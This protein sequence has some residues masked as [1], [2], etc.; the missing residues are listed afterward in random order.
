MLA[1]FV[2]SGA[3]TEFR[4]DIADPNHRPPPVERGPADLTV[5]AM[6]EIKMNLDKFKPFGNLLNRQG[7]SLQELST[8]RGSI[9]LKPAQ[10]DEMVK[11]DIDETTEE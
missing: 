8:I 3:I 9:F 10:S 4:V 2:T 1:G 6:N 7:S 5:N 11:L